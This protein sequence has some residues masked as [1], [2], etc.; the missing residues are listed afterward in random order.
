MVDREHV[1]D[2]CVELCLWQGGVAE[3]PS[4][5][6]PRDLLEFIEAA[7][8]PNIL[9]IHSGW[10]SLKEAEVS[11]RLFPGS[12]WDSAFLHR[13]QPRGTTSHTTHTSGNA[14]KN[15]E[16]TLARRLVNHESTP[17]VKPI[18]C[19]EQTIGFLVGSTPTCL[20]ERI[21]QSQTP[22]RTH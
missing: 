3:H 15:A 18:Y 22:S 4:R 9:F 6:L 10:T 8:K 5:A 11:S 17:R 13:A 2:N 21:G 12:S 1:V 16:R 19:I 20:V 7:Q 14:N